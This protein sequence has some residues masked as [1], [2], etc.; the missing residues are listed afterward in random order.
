M[1][2]VLGVAFAALTMAGSLVVAS[3]NSTA[4]DAAECVA[5][6]AATRTSGTIQ[7]VS[8]TRIRVKGHTD[9]WNPARGWTSLAAKSYRITVQKQQAD[10][11]WASVNSVA[12]DRAWQ[13]TGTAG[14]YRLAYVRNCAR[15]YAA[16]SGRAV[17]ISAPAA[18]PKGSTGGSARRCD[19]NY[20]GACVPIASDVDCAGGSGNGPAYV[21]GPVRVIGRDIYDLDRDGDGIGC[22]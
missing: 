22:E 18:K 8:A 4:A 19:P 5:V 10:R 13:I 20:A 9:Y 16:S 11:T 2:R 21:A 15:P 6:T 12:P 17:R 7:R 3:P 14:V 1:Q